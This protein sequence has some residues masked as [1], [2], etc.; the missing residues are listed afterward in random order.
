MWVAAVIGMSFIKEVVQESSTS[1]TYDPWT[2]AVTG[3]YTYTMCTLQE[4]S[5]V[6]NGWTKFFFLFNLYWTTYFFRNV[7]LMIVTANLSGWYFDT[8]GYKSFW[9]QALRWG[10]VDLAGG[11][12]ICSFTMGLA[13]YLLD[14]VSQPWRMCLAILNPIDWI[15]LCIA[16][17]AKTILHAFTKFGLISQAYTGKPFC[18]AAFAGMNLLKRQL[19]TA[20]LTDYIGTRVM[21]WATYIIALGVAF[22]TW[23]W[24]DHLQG[25]ESITEIPAEAIIAVMLGFAWLLSYPFY[26]LILVIYLEVLLR[27]MG[28]CSDSWCLE[29]RAIC[30]AIFA[31]LFLGSVVYFTMATVSEIVVNAMDTIFFCFA[32]EKHHDDAK[33][34]RFAG[35]Y[36][37][38]KAAVG[39][40]PQEAVVGAPPS[41]RSMQVM[42]PEGAGEGVV[43]RVSAPQGHSIDVTVPAGFR[44][45]SVMTLTVPNDASQPPIV[46]PPQSAAPTTNV[47]GSA[48]VGNA[49]AVV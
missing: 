16:C 8:E 10:F 39:T 36:D 19:G 20:V 6:A 9:I 22:A 12:A 15:L 31:A 24:A 4:V 37:S 45:G 13:S 18:D 35:L 34:E 5:W 43:L 30:N 2:G 26:C 17:A 1:N 23:A 47:V 7:N 14:R 27:P 48:Q 3:T 11:N 40:L 29:F 41:S 33:Q 44:A 25:V 38:L 32:V 46:H 21:S 42:V 49:E 28:N